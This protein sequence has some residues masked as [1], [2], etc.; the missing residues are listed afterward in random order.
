MFASTSK[1]VA[2]APTE[3]QPLACADYLRQVHR[4]S[5]RFPMNVHDPN[6]KNEGYR[7]TVKDPNV[8][9]GHFKRLTTTE[10]PFTIS[11]H[12]EAYDR[13]RWKIYQHGE[14]YQ[15]ARANILTDLLK[16]ASPGARVIDIGYVMLCCLV[17]FIFCLVSCQLLIS[18]TI[19]LLFFNKTVVSLVTTDCCQLPW[20]NSTSTSL[21]PA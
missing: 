19:V 7:V 12:H 15:R 10:F 13:R 2:T 14:Y 17:G 20:E 21:N 18:L 5:Y 6:H 9:K 3:I 8:K 11:L 16:E 4:G 1:A